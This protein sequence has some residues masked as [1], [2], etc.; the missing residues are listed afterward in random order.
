MDDAEHARLDQ[1]EVDI[2]AVAS[3]LETV[4]RI[5]AESSDGASAAGEIA[6][7]VSPGRFPL[8]SDPAEPVTPGTDLQQEQP[9]GSAASESDAP[10]PEAPAPYAA[11]PG[12]PGSDAAVDGAAMGTSTGPAQDR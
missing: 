10:A 9:K 5:V 3:A 8:D 4:D 11:A 1:L 6:A 2:S 7:V 12:E